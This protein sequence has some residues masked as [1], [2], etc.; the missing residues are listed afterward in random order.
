MDA[1]ALRHLGDSPARIEDEANG[2]I[3]L[4]LVKR[5]R[6]ATGG[7]SAGCQRQLQRVSTRSGTVQE[8]LHPYRP[9][10]PPHTRV[11]QGGPESSL[12]PVEASQGLA[13]LRAAP[14]PASSRL[15]YPPGPVGT[16]PR[17]S[18]RLVR[19]TGFTAVYQRHYVVLPPNGR[20]ALFTVGTQRVLGS[21]LGY[22]KHPRGERHG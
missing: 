6:V 19:W 7:S 4:L 17:R 15:L 8:A 2:L 5:R 18:K 3:L 20:R 13:R 16:C 10:L 12:P 1:D 11:T 14:P 9:G 21:E 22:I